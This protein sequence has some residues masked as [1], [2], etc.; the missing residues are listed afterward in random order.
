MSKRFWRDTSA[1]MEMA[2]KHMKRSS[3]LLIM[4]YHHTPAIKT[5]MNEWQ[6]QV[7][8]RKWGTGNSHTGLLGMQNSSAPREKLCI[9]LSF[10]F[11]KKLFLFYRRM[12]ALQ[13]S[14]VF[15][16]PSTWNSR[17]YTYI[18]SCLNLPPISRPSHLSRLI[19]S[20]CLSF[21]SHTANSRWLSI[22]HM[23]R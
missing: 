20:S 10:F 9:L 16:Q 19:Q 5:K 17:R 15:C 12:I 4:N 3:L 1:E 8:T 6:Y 21:L 11:L 23:V 18:P 2:Y 14:V 22:L 7:L 13:N